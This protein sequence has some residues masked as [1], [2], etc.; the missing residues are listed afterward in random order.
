MP[1]HLVIVESPAKAKT[2]KRFLGKDFA[3]E[4]SMGHIRDLPSNTLAVDTEHGF[5]PEYEVPAEKQN[6]VK[7]LRGA[8]KES[9]ELWIATDEDREG[10]AIGWH[11]TQVLKEDPKTVKRIVF[12]EITE[13]AIK[14]AVASPRTLDM[15]L[16]EAQQARRVLDRLVGYTLS[17]F[18]WK[19][20][21]RGLSAGRVQSVAVRMIVDRE[22]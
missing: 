12:H 6:V 13:P 9:D 16:V 4:A 22:R 15:K 14:E 3:V 7:K 8:L 2:I 18:L 17:P 11:L 5:E 20:V 1:K 19:K 10:E 21:Y